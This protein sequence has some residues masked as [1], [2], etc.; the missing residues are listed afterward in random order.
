MTTKEAIGYLKGV[1]YQQSAFSRF[2]PFYEDG[3][4]YKKAVDVLEADLRAKQTTAKLDMGRWSG[5][6]MCRGATA[7]S[8]SVFIHKGENPVSSD[9]FTFGT[10]G[11][12]PVCGK[13]QTEKALA[14]LEMRIG[15]NDGTTDNQ[16]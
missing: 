4:D 16:T 13:P 12:C 2:E 1:G 7:L 15:G 6:R 11:F 3:S 5:C 9:G 14:E 8:G 10:M